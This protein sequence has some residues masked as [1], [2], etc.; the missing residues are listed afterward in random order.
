MFVNLTPALFSE[1]LT[2]NWD[3][4]LMFLMNFIRIHYPERVSA[5]DF[6]DATAQKFD[7]SDVVLSIHRINLLLKFITLLSNFAKVF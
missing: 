4:M 1:C 5:L 7:H 6:K 2:P 3:D